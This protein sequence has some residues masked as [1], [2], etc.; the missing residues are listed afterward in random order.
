MHLL[1]PKYLDLRNK[2]LKSSKEPASILRGVVIITL[3]A[4]LIIFTFIGVLWMLEQINRQ[5]ALFFVYPSVPLSMILVFVF[6]ILLFTNT[7]SS[8]GSLYFSKE[9]DLLLSTPVS[10]EKLFTSKL[11][12]ALLSSSWM[13]I[14]FLFPVLLGFGVFYKADLS[15]YILG[16]FILIPYFYIPAALS[17]IVA[18]FSVMLIPFKLRKKAL[19][20]SVYIH[21]ALHTRSL[22]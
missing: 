9:L 13:T 8:L 5:S 20:A 7:V 22:R 2:F 21:L 11:T 14:V 4:F 10:G 1:K 18:T 3:T 17:V 15:Y 16:T 6:F 19:Y 12:E